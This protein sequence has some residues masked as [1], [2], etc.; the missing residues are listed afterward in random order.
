MSDFF[1]IG[2]S[3]TRY[4][5]FSTPPD[6]VWKKAPGNYIFVKQTG[7][8][9]IVLYAG[10]CQ[11]FSLRIPNHDRWDAAVALGIT[12][13]FSHVGN[14]NEDVRKAEERDI[15]QGHNPPMN[16]QHRIDRRNVWGLR[17]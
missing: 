5:Y 10:Q 16:V 4:D 3:G 2:A 15:I 8:A 13:V 11:D 1:V 6:P 9:W 14:A 17:R 7:S 12:H